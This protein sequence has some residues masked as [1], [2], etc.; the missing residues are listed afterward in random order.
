MRISK[1][2]IDNFRNFSSISVETGQSLLLV[3]ANATGKSN[4]IYALRLVLDST[5]SRRERLLTADDFWRG[6][7]LRPWGGRQIQ[8]SVEITD[9][10]DNPN[11]RSFLDNYIGIHV[12]R[13]ENF[14]EDNYFSGNEIDIDREFFLSE[15]NLILIF[16]IIII[17]G[18]I[19]ALFLKIKKKRK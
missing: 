6:E 2:E 13:S 17:I 19:G 16:G 7:D 3:G 5:L 15:Y 12:P 14:I 8:I 18:I 10:T 1:I 9:Y 4:F 11:L